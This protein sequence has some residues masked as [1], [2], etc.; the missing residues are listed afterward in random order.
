VVFEE[1]ARLT[2][3]VALALSTGNGD[4]S[5][6]GSRAGGEDAEDESGTGKKKASGGY[7]WNLTPHGDRAGLGAHLENLQ[8][9]VAVEGRRPGCCP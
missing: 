7:S 3:M 6:G 5:S 8:T 4:A 2:A 9:V 1:D